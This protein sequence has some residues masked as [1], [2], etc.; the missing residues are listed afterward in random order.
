MDNSLDFID[1]INSDFP[2]KVLDVYWVEA[3]NRVS[4]NF[5]K[6]KECNLL[7][8]KWL[9]YVNNND[10]DIVWQ[11]IK[12]ATKDGLLGIK[13][14]AA[15]SKLNINFTS[16]N[17]K[18]VCVY[19]YNWLDK[20][21]VFRIENEIRKLN[22]KYALCYKTDEDTKKGLYKNKGNIRISKYYSPAI[23]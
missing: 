12:K 20:E 23:K 22:I 7:A 9:I 16:E 18:I 19:T 1:S 21:D 4:R 6:E 10:I 8:G 17:E 5:A 15:T 13:S 2:S 14:K 3:S 11:K